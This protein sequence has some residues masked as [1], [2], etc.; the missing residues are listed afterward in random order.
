M[1]DGLSS[2]S[3]S[4]SSSYICIY[5]CLNTQGGY[6]HVPIPLLK[7]SEEANNAIPVS[8]RQY[9][10]SYVGGNTGD[11]RRSMIAKIMDDNDKVRNEWKMTNNA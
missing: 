2:S 10:L 11:L 8:E 3:S 4:S 1:L 9:L 5:I 7:Q 6:G